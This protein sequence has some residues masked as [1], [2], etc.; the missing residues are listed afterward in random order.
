[1]KWYTYCCTCPQTVYIRTSQ[2][3]PVFQLTYEVLV[4]KR[5]GTLRRKLGRRILFELNLDHRRRCA[6]ST[7]FYVCRRARTDNPS[8]CWRCRRDGGAP[9][10]NGLDYD[11]DS[12]QCAFDFTLHALDLGLQKFL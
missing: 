9:R 3:R 6:A 10:S 4:P 12:G 11:F 2:L 5:Y 7:L 1:L 8:A